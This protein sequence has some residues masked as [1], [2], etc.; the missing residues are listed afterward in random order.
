M[1]SGYGA[2]WARVG[3]REF[4]TLNL[5]AEYPISKKWV[6]LLEIY[7]TWTWT[8]I[9]TPQGFQSPST[10]LGVL[11][12]IEYFITEKWAVS[13]GVALD[14]VGKFGGRKYTPLFTVYYNF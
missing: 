12:G 2:T 7:S 1:G 5:A 14:L 3:S 8:N 11:P 4:V 10:L 9:S 13:A 6:A